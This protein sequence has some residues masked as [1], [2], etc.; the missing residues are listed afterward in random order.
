MSRAPPVG[1]A[2]VSAIGN[3]IVMSLLAWW[4]AEHSNALGDD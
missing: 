4:S 2:N 3:V 1:H